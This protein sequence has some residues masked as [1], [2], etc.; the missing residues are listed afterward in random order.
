MKSFHQ[1]FLIA[2]IT[3][4]SAAT[5]QANGTTSVKAT[6]TSTVEAGTCTAAILDGNGATVTA[7]DFGDVYKSDLV[8]ESRTEPLKIAFTKCVGVASASVQ[9]TPTTGGCSGSASNGNSF[10]ASNGVAFEVWNGK[11]DSGTLM[12][13]NKKPAQNVSIASG[14]GTLDMISRIVIASGR[15]ITDVTTGAVSSSVTFLI[16]YQ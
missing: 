6:F 2:V 5:A 10:P 13:C 11:A 15:S 14:S 16:T 1:L 3:L 12:D 7:I 8:A 4:S 9:A